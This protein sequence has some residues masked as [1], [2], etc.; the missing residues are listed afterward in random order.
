VTVSARLGL[1]RWDWE[2][3]DRFAADVVRAESLGFGYA[4]LP[5]N[6]LAQWDVYVLLALAARATTKIRLAPF[7]DNPVLRHPAVLAGSIA[8]V[9]HLAQGRADLVLG[10]G[11]TAVRFAGRRP[12]T[13]HE[14]EEATSLARRLLAG[15]SVEVGAPRPARLHHPPPTPVPVWL[16]AGG[17]RTL[18]MAGRVAD[19]VYLRVGR[20]PLNLRAAVDHVRAGAVEAGRDPDSIAFGLVIQ[21][22]TAQDPEG[23]AAITRSMAA[24]FYEYSP[25]L[26][27]TAGIPWDGPAVAELQ[28]KVWPD[29]HHAPDLVRSGGLVSF[30][31]EAAAAGFSLY[32]SPHDLASQLREAMGSLPHVDVVVPHPV[33]LPA[34]GSD[35][36]RWFSEE[37]WP[38]AT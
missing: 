25:A 27:D 31:P 38:L 28:T 30:L 20:H 3:P 22:V 5:T 32:G 15:E 29:F 12:A 26:F 16:A 35:F 1:N 33:P 6:P 10:V 14:L 36:P 21:T 18:R 17:P 13:V 4:L 24:G 2:T 19:G 8:T 34:P 11:D 9:D 7:L 23:I 37:V